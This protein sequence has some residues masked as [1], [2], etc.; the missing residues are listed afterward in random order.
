MWLK[1]S[2]LPGS[3]QPWGPISLKK[4][5]FYL[6][7]GQL[8]GTGD[9]Q[10]GSP[11]DDSNYCFI[12]KMPLGK[13]WE[14]GSNSVLSLED[15]AGKCWGTSSQIHNLETL[16]KSDILLWCFALPTYSISF[17]C[18]RELLSH[19]KLGSWVMKSCWHSCTEHVDVFFLKYVFLLSLLAIWNIWNENFFQ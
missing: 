10:D 15:L 8:E 16:D 4:L 13:G 19:L 2:S 14:W 9:L 1:T 5:R 3:R 17:Q 12:R 6:M 7:L 11:P 18:H